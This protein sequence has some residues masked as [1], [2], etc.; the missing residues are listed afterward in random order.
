LVPVKESTPFEIVTSVANV[1]KVSLT[2]EGATKL[3]VAAVAEAKSNGLPWPEDPIRLKPKK[4][5]VELV[6]QSRKLADLA[7]EEGE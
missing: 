3:L 7:D 1:V 5:L 4:A 6:Q 2:A